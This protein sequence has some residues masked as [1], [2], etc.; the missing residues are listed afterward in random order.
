MTL[1]LKNRLCAFVDSLHFS[2]EDTDL[3]QS[4]IYG[5]TVLND[6][7]LT[8]VIEQLRDLYGNDASM[9]AEAVLINNAYGNALDHLSHHGRHT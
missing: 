3:T 9:V 7:T 1:H 8:S 2:L 5:K 6:L 4:H